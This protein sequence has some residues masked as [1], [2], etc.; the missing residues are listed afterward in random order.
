MSNSFYEKLPN[1]LLVDFYV[2]IN[3]NI[4]NGILTDTMYVELELIEKVASKLELRLGYFEM[5]KV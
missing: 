4:E 2:E 3:K 5:K 1:D